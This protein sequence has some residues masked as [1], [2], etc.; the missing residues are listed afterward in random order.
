MSVHVFLIQTAI[1]V[2]V[3]LA[4][5]YPVVAYAGAVLHTE[6]VSLLALSVFVFTVGSVL[7]EAMGMATA[8]EGVYLLSSLCFA[9]SVWL[10]AREFLRVTDPSFGAGDGREESAGF[11]SAPA[12]GSAATE[13]GFADATEGSDGE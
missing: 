9:G 12:G 8:S 4:V 5:L 1:L 3:S 11:D 10:F 6:A 2:V 7:E 13:G